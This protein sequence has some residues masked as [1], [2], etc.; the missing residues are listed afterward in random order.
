MQTEH[1]DYQAKCSTNLDEV[2]PLF[3]LKNYIIWTIALHK[4]LKGV[5]DYH[6]YDLLG[7]LNIETYY[8]IFEKITHL[9]IEIYLW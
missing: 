8:L 9:V 1:C 4:S 2:V 6:Y 3:Y 5:V 7:V